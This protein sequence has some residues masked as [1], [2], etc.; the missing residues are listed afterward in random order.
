MPHV[1]VFRLHSQLS[2]R[3]RTATYEAFKKAD[4]GVLFTTD[5]VA[6]GI[7]LA[8]IDFVVQYDCPKDIFDYVHRVGRTARL[9]APGESVLFLMPTEVF[10]KKIFF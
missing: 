5:V 8:G 6:R 9:G 10:N 7:D 1:P 2:S 3:S 4:K